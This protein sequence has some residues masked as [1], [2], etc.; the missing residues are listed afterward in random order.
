MS[1]YRVEE[2]VGQRSCD[3][4]A[5]GH[6]E[7]S[8]RA[9]ALGGLGRAGEARG[10]IAEL[11]SAHRRSSLAQRGHELAIPADSGHCCDLAMGETMIV[12]KPRCWSV[13]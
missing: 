5:S 12:G 8:R 11:Q 7:R 4:E 10:S 6:P 9:A 2:R 13:G 3:T 1:T